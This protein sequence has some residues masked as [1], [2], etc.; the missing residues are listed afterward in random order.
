MRPLET[1]RIDRHPDGAIDPSRHMETARRQ[2]SRQARG[3]AKR[4]FSE[5][6]LLPLLTRA[7]NPFRI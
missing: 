5:R 7:L 6:R 4:L 3:M 1:P 2:R